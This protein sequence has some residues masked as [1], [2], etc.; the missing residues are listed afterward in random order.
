MAAKRIHP[1]LILLAVG[2]VAVMGLLTCSE[3]ESKHQPMEA[4]PTFDENKAQDGDTQ[5]NTIK[6][7][8]AYAKEAVHQSESLNKS[9]QEQLR[10]MADTRE[11]VQR[12]E[13]QRSNVGQDIQ[14]TRKEI[15]SLAVS[16]KALKR[17]L[18]ALEKSNKRARAQIQQGLPKGFGFDQ[19]GFVMPNET[20]GRWYESASVAP[21]A[22]PPKTNRLLPERKR[23]RRDRP[24]P[25]S[26]Q[27]AEIHQPAFT[28]PKDSTLTD[29]L[30]LTA[31]IGR[32]PVGGQTPD[33]YPVKIYV[34]KE[35]LLAN[36]HDLPEV[37]GMIFSGLGFGDWNLQC[38]S[39]RLMSATYIFSDGSIV[40]HSSDDQPLGYISD[41]SGIP[42]LAG[43]F[44]SNA[45]AFLSQR[46]G[47]AALGAAGSAYA[48]AQQT[49]QTSSLSGGTTSTVTGNIHQLAGGQAV[50][51]A[52]DEVSQWLLARQKQSFDAVVVDP[53]ATVA[54][55]L[56][57][58][59]SLDQN[60]LNRR[61][62]YANNTAGHRDLD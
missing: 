41:P 40:N 50:Q 11:A 46:I 20:R 59:L 7:L 9:T 4:V 21:P 43:K 33:P 52:T 19:E 39:A 17:Q 16:V 29:G 6:A 58:S 15:K 24:S 30:A 55:H 47:L 1:I 5:S 49:R 34:G 56:D 51:S 14:S 31:L 36:G 12:L 26:I 22:I 28:I 3:R 32:I 18:D 2:G 27:V 62:R 44:V 35:N 10:Q 57:Q 8:Q 13:Q 37:E 38:V 54:I 61:V 48:E 60:S 45:P 53:G 42:C 25:V 23:Q